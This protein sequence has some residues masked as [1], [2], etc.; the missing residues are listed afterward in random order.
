MLIII[1]SLMLLACKDDLNLFCALFISLEPLLNEAVDV[2][3][4]EELPWQ[5]KPITHGDNFV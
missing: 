4:I 2:G 1:K 3:N 5:R